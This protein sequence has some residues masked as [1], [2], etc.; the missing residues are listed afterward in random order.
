MSS[1]LEL[2]RLIESRPTMYIGRSD[3]YCL[4]AYLDGWVFRSP[5]TVV[6]VELMNDFQT[7]IEQKY[8]NTTH[9]WASIIAFYSIDNKDEIPL[10]F[11]N[12]NQFVKE[13]GT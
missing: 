1:I 3:I 10:F 13:R 8:S 9:S 7:W 12:F 4:Q 5:E 2:I 6:D 11:K